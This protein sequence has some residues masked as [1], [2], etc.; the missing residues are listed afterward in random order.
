MKGKTFVVIGSNCFTGAHVVDALLERGDKV[1]GVSR[2]KESKALY[3]PYK[4]RAKADFEFK[5]LDLVTQMDKILAL[6]A[7]VRPAVVINV[8]GL[9][10]VGL[11]NETPIE[12]YETNTLAIAKLTDFL[13][14]QPWLERYV[15][16][17]SAEI[18]GSCA[19][20]VDEAAL[21][22]PSTPY[23]VSKAAAD[24]HINT[25]IKNFGFKATMIRSTNVY[26]RHQQLFKIIPRT[27]IN[28]K[29]GK[30][31]E[32]HGGGTSK[33][34]FV[35]IR[36]VVSGLLLALEKGTSGTYHFTEISDLS[37]ADV[38]RV[39]CEL[40]GRDFAKCA[41]TVGERLGQDSAYVL[42]SSKA[43]KELGWK[44][45]VDFKDG[46]K[47]TVEWIEANWAAVS[48]EPHNYIHRVSG[49]EAV[50]AS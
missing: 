4:K 32:L 48:A 30:M 3:L 1:I 7:Q 8:A 44:P 5:Q 23:A 22:N 14:R 24:M 6:L 12:Y 34:C 37:V 20:P 17:S 25:L 46:V 45:T 13:R 2:A 43:R 19:K 18:F 11:S 50:G 38:V 15:H 31:I 33:K 27:V 47:E 36:D 35:H 40:M 49:R 26:G 16:I 41:K 9:T 39:T 28:V 21:F 42:D 29:L 10:E